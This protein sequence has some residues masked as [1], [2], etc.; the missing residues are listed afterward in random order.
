MGL[1]K[2]MKF[3]RAIRKEKGWK[4]WAMSKAMGK[5]IQSYQSLEKAT[6]RIALAD[7]VKIYEISGLSL[8]A[9]WKM[10]ED[11]VKARKK[12]VK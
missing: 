12:T 3:L 5:P 6:Q 8:E 4:P 1:V 7:L 2:G 9:F 11:E 10:I